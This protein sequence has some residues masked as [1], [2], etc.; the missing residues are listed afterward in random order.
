MEGKRHMISKSSTWTWI[1]NMMEAGYSDLD[2]QLII[3][4]QC[5]ANL[6]EIEAQR[7]LDMEVLNAIIKERNNHD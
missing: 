2:I 1:R 5:K 7:R 6:E 3:D 4:D